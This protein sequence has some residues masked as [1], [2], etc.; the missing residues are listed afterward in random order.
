MIFCRLYTSTARPFSLLGTHSLLASVRRHAAAACMA[1]GLS[2]ASFG[3]FAADSYADIKQALSTG[4]PARAAELVRKARAQHPKDVQLMFF[5]GVIMA[6]TGDTRGAVAVFEQMADKYP[7][8]PEP[9]NNLGV[10]YA[11]RGDLEKAKAAFER[12]ILTNPSYAAA[13]KNM[14]D[15]YAV[16]AKQ[17]YGKALQADV[18]NAPKAP[19]MTLLG[20]IT[21]GSAAKD[22]VIVASAETQ[23]AKAQPAA[24]AEKAEPQTP[25]PTVQPEAP[26]Q[27]DQS[28]LAADVE[29]SVMAWAGA[30]SKRDIKGYLASYSDN[31]DPGRLSLAAWKQQR[32]DRIVPRKR[33]SVG[34]SKLR[35]TVDSDKASVNFT[36]SYASDTFNGTSNKRLNMALEDGRWLIVKESVR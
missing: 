23:Q 9:H 34:I 33:I 15:V 10:L 2:I 24:P 1:S 3:A 13:H 6:Q 25:E 18:A 14:A 5:D 11:A 7:E 28:Q 20:N 21:P 22:A 26:T 12:A 8:L 32:T 27:P 17:N 29:Q 31:F 30:W 16:L 19:Q 4:E 36:Q 35:V